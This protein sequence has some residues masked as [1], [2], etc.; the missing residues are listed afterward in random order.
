LRLCRQIEDAVRLGPAKSG[1]TA[2]SN[3]LQEAAIRL[4]R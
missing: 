1:S 4:P 2:H 3:A